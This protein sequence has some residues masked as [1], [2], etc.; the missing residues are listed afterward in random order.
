[1]EYHHPDHDMTPAHPGCPPE[2]ALLRK[3]RLL[4]FIVPSGSDEEGT[5]QALY[6]EVREQAGKVAEDWEILFV[7]HGGEAGTERCIET[8]SKRDPS[9]VRPFRV[10]GG[11]R[12]GALA[13]GY[14][15]ARGEYVF[16]LESDQDNDLREIA[17]FM[18]KIVRDAAEGRG[19]EPRD[20]WEKILPRSVLRRVVPTPIF[21][22][23]R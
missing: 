5:L 11:G 12:S 17:P 4:S 14:R 16:T 10:E 2:P 22:T 20:H 23:T 9:H 8:L 13:V 18:R 7:N 6:D 21:S 15:Q 3:V 1:M 19:G